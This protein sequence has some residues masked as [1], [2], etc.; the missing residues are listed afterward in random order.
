MDMDVKFVVGKKG[1]TGLSNVFLGMAFLV[2]SILVISSKA[3]YQYANMIDLV[4]L[5]IFIIFF[6]IVDQL[7]FKGKDIRYLGLCLLYFGATTVFFTH[8]MV[9]S[10]ISVFWILLWIVVLQNVSLRRKD[11]KWIAGI[12]FIMFLYLVVIS[13]G[14]VA[15]WNENTDNFMLNPN[16]S[17]YILTL[18]SGLL[19][20]LS[21]KIKIYKYKIISVA[22]ILLTAL[23]II[24]YASRT[25]LMVFLTFL[26]FKYIIP[27]RYKRRTGFVSAIF[28][29]I[30][31]AGCLLPVVYV[32][33]YNNMDITTAKV[34]GKDLFT[35]REW[36]WSYLFQHVDNIKFGWLF[37]IG[38]HGANY[39]DAAL[40]AHNAYMSI[41]MRFGVIGIAA[42]FGFYYRQIKKI[43]ASKNLNKSMIDMT[44]LAISMMVSGFFE[45]V[46]IWHPV[47]FFM[48]LIWALPVCLSK[49]KDDACY[50]SH[51]YI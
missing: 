46:M 7:D 34:L 49:E 31:V 23:G 43:Y 36:I 26:I 13:S 27:Y 15:R 10:A 11:I 37:G 17:G 12:S 1:K 48:G 47:I 38:A 24:H 18:F 42:F 32:F 39:A 16:T 21:D 8:D 22:H 35:G 28:L 4:L 44:M 30:V 20:S 3:Y 45:T 51:P 33:M 6:L 40:N 14:Y 19:L 9:S 5:L 25:A 50:G 29:I 2:M 41:Y